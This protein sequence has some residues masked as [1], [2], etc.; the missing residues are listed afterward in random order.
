M[1]LYKINWDNKQS[2]LAYQLD[3]KSNT[4]S[5]PVLNPDSP[6]FLWLTERDIQY[7]IHERDLYLLLYLDIEENQSVEFQ[8]TWSDIICH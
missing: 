6:L 5:I 8:L 2:C 4:F 7:S 1:K 3:N